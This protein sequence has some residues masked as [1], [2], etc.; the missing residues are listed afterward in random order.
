VSF[1][2]FNYANLTWTTGAHSDGD[3]RTGLGGSPAVVSI[4]KQLLRLK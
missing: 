1:L 3:T 4:V 2:I